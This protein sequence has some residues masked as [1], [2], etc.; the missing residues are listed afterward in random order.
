[1]NKRSYQLKD[2]LIN[3]EH[4]VCAREDEEFGKYV[5]ESDSLKELDKRT[6]FT[7]VSLNRGNMGYEIVIVSPLEKLEKDIEK[8]N[9]LLLKG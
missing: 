1:M 2:V 9:K 5:L 4:I 3:P 6:K 8:K 7:R